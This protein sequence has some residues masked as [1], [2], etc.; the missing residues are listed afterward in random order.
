MFK[1]GCITLLLVAGLVATVST[2]GTETTPDET[3]LAD[4]QRQLNLDSFDYVWTTIRDKHFDPQL[5]GLD[6]PAIREELRPRVEQ[7]TAQSDARSAMEEMISRLEQSHFTI[8]PAKVYADLGRP[9]GSGVWDGWTGIEARVLDGRALVTA[10]HA[11][12]PAEEAGVRPG[13]IIQSIDG[14]E[15]QPKIEAIS[16][17]LNGQVWKDAVLAGSL[18]WRLTGSVGDTLTLGLLDGGDQ[19]VERTITLAE[20]PGQK[21]Q[22]GYLPPLHIWIKV[23]LLEESIGYIA[24]NM[25]LD[26]AGVMPVFNEAMRSFMS[27]EGLIID[28]RGNRGGLP[29]MAMGMAGWLVAEKSRKLG[30]AYLRDNELKIIVNP[31][32]TTYAGP[33]AILVD[34]LS[35]SASEIFS[36]GLKDLGRAKI[37]GTRTTGAV[38]PSAIERLPNGDGFQYVVATYVSEG[39]EV[40]EGRGVTPDIEVVPTREELLRGRDPVL[41]AAIAWIRDQ[42]SASK[43][44]ASL[45]D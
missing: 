20:Q 25:F 1:K 9:T 41:D 3:P 31:R 28:I 42:S 26:P 11:A 36:G 14:E 38:L 29:G 21:Q 27:A 16:E 44:D 13:W 4:E 10:V 43:I 33:V 7:A 23:K 15:V 32:P 12:T 5:G 17:E 8:I 22:F 39:G 18:T 45:P 34:C 6:W 35:G 30:T 37:V 24:F 40:L 2:A 19:R